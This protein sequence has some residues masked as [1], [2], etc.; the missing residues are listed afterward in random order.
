MC[1]NDFQCSVA[2]V[3]LLGLDPDAHRCLE[4]G[5]VVPVD[6]QRLWHSAEQLLAEPLGERAVEPGD[7]CRL[8]AQG[9]SL[10]LLV[11]SDENKTPAERLM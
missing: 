10:V 3:P 11:G 5:P 4:H 8:D 7:L 9:I 1:A 6:A 2:P